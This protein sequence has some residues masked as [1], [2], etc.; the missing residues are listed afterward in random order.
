MD[1]QKKYI[2]NNLYIYCSDKI[3]RVE[4]CFLELLGS[5]PNMP[6]LYPY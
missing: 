4:V 3:H 1:E 2:D 5:K 6:K